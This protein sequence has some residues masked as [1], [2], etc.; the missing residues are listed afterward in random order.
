M[1]NNVF[2]RKKEKRKRVMC[3]LKIGSLKLIL[4]FWILGTLNPSL[5][6]FLVDWWRES[7]RRLCVFF[8][9]L[10]L[11][12]NGAK[13]KRHLNYILTKKNRTT[14]NFSKGFMLV[15]SLGVQLLIEIVHILVFCINK[16]KICCEF[17]NWHKLTKYKGLMCWS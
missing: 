14:V 10:F 16:H 6:I 11:R 3:N 7:L 17:L 4:S 13:W 9:Y 1:R 2:F 5:F 12:S 8:Y 15:I